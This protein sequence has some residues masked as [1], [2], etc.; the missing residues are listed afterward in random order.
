MPLRES[1]QP[2]TPVLILSVTSEFLWPWVVHITRIV[3]P[4]GRRLSVHAKTGVIPP[5]RI[6]PSVAR[7]QQSCEIGSLGLT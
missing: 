4:S 7:M 1:C 5:K 6:D 2:K 3:I